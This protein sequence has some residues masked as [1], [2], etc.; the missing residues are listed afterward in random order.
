MIV[1]DGC[2]LASGETGHVA[3]E[4]DRIVSAGTGDPPDGTRIDASG[5]LATPGLVNCH[6]HLYQWAT[7]GLAQQATLFEWLVELYPTWAR[8]DADIERA[9][10]RAGLASLLLSGCTTASDHHYVFPRDAGDLLEVEIE[11]AR[12][13]GIRFHPCRGSMDLGKSDGGLPPDSVVEDRDEILTACSEALE[14]WHDRSPGALLR[15]ALAPCSPFSV[16]RDLMR[17][18]AELARARGVRL[19]THMAETVEEEQFCQELFGMRPV[20]YLEDVGWLGDDVWLAH[21]VHLNEREVSRFGETRTGVAHC[22][23]SNAR[24]GAGIAP[25]VPLVRAG[26][27]VGLGVDGA[28]SAEHGELAGELRQALLFARLAGGPAAITAREAL[29]LGTIHGARCLGWDDELGKLEPGSLADIV[30]WR[31]DDLDH[32]GIEDPVAALVLGARPLADRVFVGG[33]EVVRGGELL[34][35]DVEEIARDLAAMRLVPA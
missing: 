6:H 33:R 14:R 23:S 30:L 34:T 18:C 13:L 21:C 10:A 5:C 24:L 9:A 27:P 26:A 31:L 1:L 8:I 35:A 32:A 29:D 4:G 7:R 16:T 19:H 3:F 11:A 12:E 22:P 2:A 28:A 15:I 25:V 17:E 20:E